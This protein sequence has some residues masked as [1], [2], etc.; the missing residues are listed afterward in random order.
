MKDRNLAFRRQKK[1]KADF[2]NISLVMV[3]SCFLFLYVVKTEFKVKVFFL[4]AEGE[5]KE[6]CPGWIKQTKSPSG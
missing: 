1:K 6:G 2:L 3:F 5:E 4:R